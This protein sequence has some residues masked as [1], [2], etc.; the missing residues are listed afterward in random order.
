MPSLV[1]DGQLTVDTQRYKHAKS[2][3]QA[4]SE[5]MAEVIRAFLEGYALPPHL[6]S[7]FVLHWIYHSTA[8]FVRVNRE[9][10]CE[11]SIL[12]IRDLKEGL[13]MLNKRW[14]SAGM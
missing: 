8:T 13:K 10:A 12:I 5:R 2:V 3:I 14:K 6:V 7:P 4:V 11:E 9:S 1:T